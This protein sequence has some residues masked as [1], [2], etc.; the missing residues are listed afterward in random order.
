M[1]SMMS[2]CFLRVGRF[3]VSIVLSSGKVVHFIL[4]CLLSTP[5][6]AHEYWLSP[7]DYHIEVGEKLIVDIRNGEEFVGSAFPYDSA[8]Y[9][10]LYVEYNGGKFPVNSRLGDYP[11][12]H[13]T[14]SKSGHYTVALESTE[15]LLTYE[16]WEKF[17]EFLDY[18]GLDAF[19]E[20]HIESDLPRTNIKEHYYRFAKSLIS[21]S[22]KND[23]GDDSPI[24][25]ALNIHGQELEIVLMDSPYSARSNIR[26]KLLFKGEPLV[27][28]QVE[29]FHNDG[30][31]NRTTT[32]TDAKGMALINIS[33]KGEYMINAV[34]L[35]PSD[36]A[37]MHWKSLWSSFTFR[38]I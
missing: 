2:N 17:S 32:I 23:F 26:I 36:R 13:K 7:I 33:D 10:S 22:G 18:H 38:R 8:Q 30:T 11:A 3:A 27:D 14:L 25:D 16:T 15:R 21:V 5:L 12:I 37:G 20:R 1:L 19:A 24:T 9:Q 6:H 4:F 35:L 34:K 31:V 28:R 29:V